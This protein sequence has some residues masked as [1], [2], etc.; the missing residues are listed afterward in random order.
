MIIKVTKIQ[1]TRIVA[2]VEQVEM[3]QTCCSPG[4]ASHS[5]KLNRGRIYKCLLLIENILMFNKMMFIRQAIVTD[6][7]YSD[8]VHQPSKRLGSWC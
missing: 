1:F 3:L 8:Y 6:Q 7:T 2:I 4:P 5:D